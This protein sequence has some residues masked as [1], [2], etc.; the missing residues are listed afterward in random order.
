MTLY[1]YAPL[2]ITG[3]ILIILFS[4]IFYIL[5]QARK[6]SELDREFMLQLE[7]ASGISDEDY[8]K[9]KEIEKNKK[10]IFKS[11]NKLWGRILLY[12]GILSKDK[13]TD[14]QAGQFVFVATIL[15]YLLVCIMFNNYG[16][17]MIPAVGFLFL[18]MYYGNNKISAKERLFEDQIPSFLATLKANIQANETPERALINAIENTDDPLF[19]ELVIAKSLTEAGTFKSAIRQLR[20]QSKN[21]TLKFLCSCIELSTREGANLES[22]IVTIEKMLERKRALKRKLDLAIQEN[23]PLL[24]VSSGLIPGLFIL[25]YLTNEQTRE[26]W[27]NSFA[28]WI[29]FFLVIG[30][31]SLGVWAANRIIK[32]TANF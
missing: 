8:I 5:Y 3:F 17:G 31:F 24:L 15:I 22:Q 23:K 20:K 10:G 26:F 18:L 9:Q 21:Q 16:I 19:S 14:Q 13:Y 2:F 30:I 28:S 25:L 7:K 4:V 12:S 1:A 32:K 29:V 11:W 27:F 6:T